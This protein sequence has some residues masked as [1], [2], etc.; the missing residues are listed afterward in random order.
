MRALCAA[1]LSA[2]YFV[3]SACSPGPVVGAD[4]PGHPLS[5]DRRASHVTAWQTEN[6]RDT[7]VSLVDTPEPVG[8]LTL[9][10]AMAAA[11]S[12]GPELAAYA[13]QVRVAEAR[14]LQAG[15]WSNPEL[16]VEFENFGGSGGL[17]GTRSL[18]TTISL[19][20][21]FPLGGDP[22]R[23]RE[24]ARHQTRLADWDY[25]SARLEVLTEVTRRYIA[26][27]VAHRR[28]EVAQEATL[29][30]EQV[31]AATNKRVDA[32][33]AP[34]IEVA[35]AR[36]P[37][38]LAQ[39]ALKRAQ[40][41]LQT[42]R[43]QLSLTW[44]SGE[45]AF[46]SLAG[47]LD[48]L[49]PPPAAEQLVSLVNQNP[50]VAR[51]ATEVSARRA[52]ARLAQA[53]AVPDVTGRIG[54]RDDRASDAQALVVGISL[55]LPIFDNRRGDVLAAR[56]GAA[57]ARQ[58]QRLAE[59]RIESMLSRAYA[60]L[61]DAHDQATAIRDIALPPA[62]E[63][64]AAARRAFEQGH[65]TYLDVLDAQRTLLELR[66][67]HLDALAAYHES[68]AEIEGLVCRP[69]DRLTQAPDNLPD[70]TQEDSR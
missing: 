55:P 49:K 67:E 17:S 70:Q 41:E 22:Q 61:V 56:L 45:P 25:E 50:A 2:V 48:D 63:A 46:E 59:L 54:L 24:V 32:G 37:V 18:E 6:A 69:L 52:E 23:H 31:Q 65:L 26:V 58:R 13:L 43:K 62:T 38:A 34:P 16:E 4:R 3:L 7:P 10:G 35:R 64:F 28:I 47:S 60:R 12:R 40:R 36:V 27:L 9:R 68:V 30:A 1:S 15:R 5:G 53:Q 20:Q 11:L 8:E 33:D 57:A 42:A 39:L 14:A 29:L 51:W 21:T 66:R 44:A 19:A